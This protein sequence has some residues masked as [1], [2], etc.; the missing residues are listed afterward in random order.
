[1]LP[2]PPITS[3]VRPVPWPCATTRTR[4]WVVSEPLIR[5]AQERFRQGRRDA[6]LHRIPARLEQHVTLAA[7]IARRLARRALDLGDL[8]TDGLAL[9]HEL[10]QV[11]IED[12]ETGA[13]FVEGWHVD[14][15][16]RQAQFFYR[17]GSGVASALCTTASRARP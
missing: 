10:E 8:G 15:G 9:G 6:E 4:S 7:E 3:A 17:C 1:M 13:Q 11:A 2:R 5:R 12:V 16:T 14:P